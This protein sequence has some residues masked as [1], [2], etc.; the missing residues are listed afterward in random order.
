MG[1]KEQKAP[2]QLLDNLN[3]LLG[4]RSRRRRGRLG[5][6]AL[7]RGLG[8]LHRGDDRIDRVA[9]HVEPRAVQD[10]GNVLG[11]V[12][13]GRDDG[14]TAEEEEEGVCLSRAKL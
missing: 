4:E 9:V 3:R 10:E 14:Q 12:Q 6:Q 5:H 2:L 8:D 7:D 11:E 13:D 1:G